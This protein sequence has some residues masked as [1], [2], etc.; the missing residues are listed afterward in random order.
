MAQGVE[1]I[2]DRLT[3]EERGVSAD[4]SGAQMRVAPP[5]DREP[6]LVGRAFDGHG[7][8]ATEG[9]ARFDGIWKETSARHAT[10]LTPPQSWQWVNEDDDAPLDAARP[11]DEIE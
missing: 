7:S 4:L 8:I 6:V 9:E 2:L 11:A 1:K 3:R 5:Q 10:Q